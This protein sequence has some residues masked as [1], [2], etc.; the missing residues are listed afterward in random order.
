M[1]I[2][3]LSHL[4]SASEDSQIF[5]GSSISV[6]AKITNIGIGFGKSFALADSL[7]FAKLELTQYRLIFTASTSSKV[8]AY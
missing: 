4:E 6:K 5:G 8:I 3:D 1:I 7:T 2:S